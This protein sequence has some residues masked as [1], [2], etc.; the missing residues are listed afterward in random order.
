[1]SVA[2]LPSNSGVDNPVS[3]RWQWW[4]VSQRPL[5]L[6]LRKSMGN[7]NGRRVVI[8]IGGVYT[9][10]CQGEGHTFAKVSR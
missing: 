9:T 1:M 4:G 6:I 3:A 10:L 7:T 8:Q 5:T 2:F